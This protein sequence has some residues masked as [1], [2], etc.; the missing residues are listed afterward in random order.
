[1]NISRP[2]ALRAVGAVVYA[3]RCGDVI[4]IGHTRNLAQRC[5]KLQADEVLAIRPGTYE[6]EQAIH[7]RLVGHLHHGREWYYPTPAVVTVVNE[8]RASLGM[9]PVAV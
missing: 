8:M 6:D 3:V 4:K 2:A 9:D 7:A 1:M 5:N